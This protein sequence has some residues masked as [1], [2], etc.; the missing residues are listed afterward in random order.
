MDNR[1]ETAASGKDRHMLSE[2][3]LRWERRDA[4]TSQLATKGNSERGRETDGEG[5]RIGV[6]SLTVDGGSCPE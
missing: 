3:L 5:M 4:T 2:K 1:G 6:R